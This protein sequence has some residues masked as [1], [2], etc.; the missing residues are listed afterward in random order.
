MIAIVAVVA[1]AAALFAAKHE[2]LGLTLLAAL[3]AGIVAYL[4]EHGDFPALG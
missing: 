2:R 4:R 3:A 1:A